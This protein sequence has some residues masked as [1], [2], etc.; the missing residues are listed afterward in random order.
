[1]LGENLIPE[2]LRVLI[3]DDSPESSNLVRMIL[4]DLNISYVTEID[5]VADAKKLLNKAFDDND[6][7][8]LIICDH[9]MPEKTGF[10][11]LV[12]VRMNLK[13]NNIAYITMTSDSQMSIVLP[14]INAGADAF[15]VKPV[16]KKELNPKLKQ[17]FEKRKANLK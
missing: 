16:S 10:E 5:N 17:I 4:K 15:I 9:H 13:F 14:Y 6:P 1:M 11:F 2:N 7:F 3:I 8:G 12:Y